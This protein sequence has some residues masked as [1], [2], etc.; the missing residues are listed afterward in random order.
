MTLSLKRIGSFESET[1]AEIAAFDPDRSLLYVVS[2]DTTLQVLDLSDPAAPNKVIALDLAELGAPIAGANSI[3][4]SNGLLAVALESETVTDPGL[5]AL[6]NLNDVASI[7]DINSALQVFSVGPLPD[8]ITFTPD[9]SKVLVA[10]EGEP[11]E[12]V[13]PDGSISIILASLQA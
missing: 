4:Y 10:N 3:A 2:G 13:D 9:G 7:D 12:G 8:M 11:D 6:V 5:V 1:G